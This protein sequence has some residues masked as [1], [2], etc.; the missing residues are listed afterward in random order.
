ML[1]PIETVL[2]IL[3]VFIC[4][5][6]AYYTWGQMFRIINK[7]QKQLYFDNFGQRL[8][9]TIRAFFSQGSI[10]SHRRTVSTFH[11]GV[12]Y[13][14][15]FF[16][17][18]TLVDLAEGL[19]PGFLFLEGNLLGDIFRLF[20]D[21]FAVI[22]LIGLLFFAIRRFGRKDPLLRA[23]ENVKLNPKARYNGINIDSLIVLVFISLHMIGSLMVS[24]SGIALMTGSNPWQPTASLLATTLMAGWPE[25]LLIFTLHAGWW[26]SIGLIVLFVPYFPL[27]KHIHLIMGPLNFMTAPKRTYPGQ[28][29]TLNFEDESIEQFGA[30]TLFDLDKTQVFDTFACIMCNRCQEVCPAYNTGKELSPAAL[31]INKRYYTK[32]DMAGSGR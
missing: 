32:A 14:F 13:G 8:W 15:I 9:V 23:R 1:S 22:V 27:T 5:V 11:Y 7:G 31:E 4:A 30:A 6:A 29:L 2:F 16:G 10:T 21:I 26:I 3:L 28:L 20:A 19:I 24:A 25:G 17:M 12:A 18:V